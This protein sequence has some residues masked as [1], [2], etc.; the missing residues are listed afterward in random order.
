MANR[1]LGILGCTLVALCG[2]IQVRPEPV[3]AQSLFDKAASDE[4]RVMSVKYRHRMD[5]IDV[6][7]FKATL[8]NNRI[9]LA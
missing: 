2:I 4:A 9:W 6:V 5:G 8:N 7:I 1:R 3:S